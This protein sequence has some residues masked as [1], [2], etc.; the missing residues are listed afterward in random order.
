M[1]KE[2]ASTVCLVR[3]SKTDI[4][5]GCDGQ[6]TRGDVI[7]KQDN[8]KIRKNTRYPVLI[9][10]T[11]SI[12]DSQFLLK[13]VEE[14]L[15]ENDGDIKK[16]LESAICAVEERNLYLGDENRALMII[17]DK[18]VSYLFSGEGEMM[19][20]NDQ[21]IAIGSGGNYALA[22]ARALHKC[23]KLNSEQIVNEAIRVAASICV[24]TNTNIT[25]ITL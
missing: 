6:I 16:S 24:Y 14:K 13:I 18:N 1:R 19:E 15:L 12:K 9:G 20:M 4:C 25:T 5:I 21:C 8:L 10:L 11:G 7:T 22:A 2:F 23:S 17:A 3:R